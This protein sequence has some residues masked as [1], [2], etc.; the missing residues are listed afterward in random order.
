MRV[1]AIRY[2]LGALLSLYS[3]TLLPPIAVSL[4]FGDGEARHFLLTL[5]LT[6]GAGLALWLPVCRRRVEL[7]RREG[8]LV[9]VLFW[10]TL[11]V[12]GSLPFHF[13]PHL[14]FTDAVFEALSGFTTT[15]A[16]VIRG[17]DG[18][19]PSILWYRQQI[20][21]LGGMGIVVLAVALFPMLGVGG[22]Q[23]YRAETPGPMKDE[24]LTPRI[25]HTAQSLWLI[26]VGLTVLCALAYRVAGMDWFDAVGHAF[27]TISTGGFSTHDASLGYFDNPW[28]E[29]VADVFMLA[30]ALNF[31]IHYLALHRRRPGLY[32]RDPEAR[33]FLAVVLAATALVAVLL[34]VLG[35]HPAPG[36]A[37]RYALFQVISVVTSTGFT[38]DA[39]ASWPSFLPIFLIYISFIGGCAGSTAGGMKVV[40]VL[41]L[42]K[43]GVREVG[44][45]VHPRGV[46]PIKLGGHVM[47]ETVVGA[48]WGFFAL[49]MA[50][51]ATLTMLMVAAGLDVLSA[52][53]AVAATL[54]VLGP[55]L[56]EVAAN[57]ASVSTAGKWVLILSM[58]LGRL[59]L[60][61]LLV[62]LSPGFWRG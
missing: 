11:G 51:T 5:A 50:A 38:T 32:L 48:V 52:F 57:F 34:A 61:T 54:N 39:F 19:P 16:T 13:S 47:S 8:F 37:L 17:L 35:R 43:Q 10:T 31:G 40:R 12:I 7:G 42:L 41:L 62:I 46:L 2:V 60:F 9:V 6:A 44:R 33:A 30:G 29:A 14:G 20:Q 26:Y 4:G 18:L 3:L 1:G 27:S 15:G 25:A 55:G 21:W 59:E 49:Y 36:E 22:M 23:L 56:G 28:I 24:K 53:S 45:L 58:L